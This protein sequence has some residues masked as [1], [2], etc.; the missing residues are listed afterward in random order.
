MILIVL[1]NRL[2][3]LLNSQDYVGLWSNSD[4][5]CSIFRKWSKFIK[6][7]KTIFLDKIV[8]IIMITENVKSFFFWFHLI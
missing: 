1:V 6:R 8:E 5:C 2:L 4:Y 3:R 7:I